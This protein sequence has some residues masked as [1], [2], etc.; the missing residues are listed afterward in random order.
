M[1]DNAPE[2]ISAKWIWPPGEGRDSGPWFDGEPGLKPREWFSILCLDLAANRARVRAATAHSLA[3]VVPH[4]P[5]SSPQIP[6]KRPSIWRR[7]ITWMTGPDV[8]DSYKD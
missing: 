2:P 7:V 6:R 1:M 4:A 5:L 3:S 8:Q